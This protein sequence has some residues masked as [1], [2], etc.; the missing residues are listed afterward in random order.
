MKNNLDND[1]ER[2][3][4]FCKHLSRVECQCEE[5]MKRY[6]NFNKDLEGENEKV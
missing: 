4:I 2:R 3:C 6:E 1:Y 5:G